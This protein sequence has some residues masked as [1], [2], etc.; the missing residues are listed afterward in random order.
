MV[1]FLHD[2]HA[3]RRDTSLCLG[4]SGADGMADCQGSQGSSRLSVLLL[5]QGMEGPDDAEETPS[6]ASWG[7]SLELEC[8]GYLKRLSVG[9]SRT[10]YGPPGL[11]L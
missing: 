9:L 1:G 6:G 2:T 7:S 11:L 4:A 8:R 10:T 3:G 5:A